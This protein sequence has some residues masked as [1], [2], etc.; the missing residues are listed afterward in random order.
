MDNNTGVA[1]T[2]CKFRSDGVVEVELPICGSIVST[3]RRFG[4]PGNSESIEICPDSTIAFSSGENH[5]RNASTSVSI[6]G[7]CGGG[8]IKLYHC[9]E[10]GWGGIGGCGPDIASWH[11]HT[12]ETVYVQ[13]NLTFDEETNTVS[14]T[15]RCGNAPGLEFGKSNI[16]VE[17]TD[18]VRIDWNKTLAPIRDKTSPNYLDPTEY[19]ILGYGG[20]VDPKLWKAMS[21]SG[22]ADPTGEME[23][24][25]FG[26]GGDNPHSELSAKKISGDY[27][28]DDKGNANVINN[29]P[30]IE[31]VVSE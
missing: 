15:A 5:G 8:D 9:L 14:G 7:F 12:G 27:T 24:A 23:R 21:K 22:K 30:K 29:E 18:S 13:G 3:T 11:T 1:K 31:G 28:I 10:Q 4:N 6:T 20:A 2:N 17:R 26:S 16:M 25:Y 19:R